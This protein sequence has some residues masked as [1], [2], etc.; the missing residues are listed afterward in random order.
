MIRVLIQQPVVPHYRVAFFNELHKNEN[1]SC[2]VHA[3][4]D[5]PGCPSTVKG[6]L[7][8]NFVSHPC[9]CLLGGEVFW[10]QNLHIPDS[11][12]G[13]DV[14][15]VCGNPRFLSTLRLIGEAKLKGLGIVWWSLE[16]SATTRFFR[17]WIRQKM[18]HLLPDICLMYTDA[19][20]DSCLKAGFDRQRLFAANNTIDASPINQASKGWNAARLYQF[21]RQNE[22]VD[23]NILLFCGRLTQKCELEVAIDTLSLLVQERQNCKLIVIGDGPKMEEYRNRARRLGISSHISWIGSVYEEEEM[24]PWFLSA[25]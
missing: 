25:D 5:V 23:Q 8:I 24:A 16:R 7:D 20:V 14:L 1:F 10:Q 3:S 6:D 15:V 22:I 12:S 9:K 11:Y 19:E 2:D 18:M 17:F 4:L 21:Q 13:G